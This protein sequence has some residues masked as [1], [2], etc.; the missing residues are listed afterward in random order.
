MSHDLHRHKE[1]LNEIARLEA[2]NPSAPRGPTPAGIL[3]A[4]LRL[5]EGAVSLDLKRSQSIAQGAALVG[6]HKSLCRPV[7]RAATGLAP[8]E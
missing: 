5:D 1:N 2:A 3:I 7:G 6:R 4:G 8:V